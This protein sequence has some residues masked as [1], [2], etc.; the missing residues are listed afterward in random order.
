VG[1]PGTKPQPWVLVAG[2]FHPHGGMDKANA[3]LARYLYRREVPLHLVGYRIDQDFLL[4]PAVKVHHVHKP[5]SFF[6]GRQQLNRS[7]RA[8][9]GE[10]TR[11][12]PG[13]RVLVNG[14]NCN[15]SGINWVHSLHQVWKPR[16]GKAPLWF[17]AKN[18]L[19]KSVAKRDELRSLRKATCV[20]ANSERTRRELVDRMALR[21][22]LVHTVYLGNDC[23]WRNITPERRSAAR[24]WLG[25]NEDRPLVA[26]VG[27]LGY[28]TN[29]G[30]DTLWTA[31]QRLCALPGWDADLIAA[32]GGRALTGWRREIERAGLSGRVTMLG[33]TDRVTDVLAASDLLVSPV[34]YESYGLNVHEAICCGVPAIVSA[35]AGIAERYPAE[36]SDMLMP[37]REDVDDL[38]AR[39]SRW[40][41]EINGFKK[42]VEPLA[43]VLRSR[44]WDDMAAQIVTLVEQ[45]DA[46]S[47]S[48]RFGI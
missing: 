15:W 44:T 4:S 35:R 9:A 38:V 19:E 30:F 20:L 48:R 33:F 10:M 11:R 6:L 26:F 43:T 39:M 16:E 24:Q 27:A 32:G 17:K 46:Q 29:K 34:R 22:E 13:A 37:D 41:S 28:D 3:A 18:R 45:T 2:G 25:K 5:G 21:P 7:G 14:G 23:D 1:L 42:R 31:W 8:V 40:R 12:F 47:C 36:L